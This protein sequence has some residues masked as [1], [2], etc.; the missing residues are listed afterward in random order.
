M[1]TMSNSSGSSRISTKAIE[2]IIEKL[3][4][5]QTRQ[6]TAKTYLAIWR[7]FNKFLL[8]LDYMPEKWEYRTILFVGYLIEKGMQS[9][10]VKSYISAIKKTL[11]NDNYEWTDVN[12]QLAS[13]TKACRMKNDVVLTRLPIYCGMLELIL[14]QVQ[15]KFKNQ[16]YLEAIYLALFAIGYYG[17][18]RVGELTLSNHVVKATNTYLATN[19][20]KL[21]LVLYSS[22]T[23]DLKNRPQKIKIESNR[24]E[25]TGSYVERHFCPFKI[26]RHFL[27]LRGY[28]YESEMEP[29]FVFIDKTPVTP[30]NARTV[31]RECIDAMNLDSSLYDI[32][33]LRIGRT[34]DLIK[35]GYSLE[36]VKLMGRWKSNAVYKYIRQ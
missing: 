19:K 25:R 23:H 6:S 32:H 27:E 30:N 17:L 2:L 10:T 11:I 22:K 9:S 20:D 5:Y 15:R 24:S 35:F 4:Y 21:L 14:F 13:L 18:M 26:I 1:D 16:P 34:N 31:L 33:S 3:K 36:E 12:V 29:L 7:Q 28:E 8:S